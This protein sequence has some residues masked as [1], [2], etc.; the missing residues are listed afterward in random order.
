MDR[1]TGSGPSQPWLAKPA[2]L[3]GLIP[4]RSSCV[5]S[6]KLAVAHRDKFIYEF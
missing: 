2:H 5:T 4:F 6:E 3:R 1:V